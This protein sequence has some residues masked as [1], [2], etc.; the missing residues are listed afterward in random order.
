MLSAAAGRWAAAGWRARLGAVRHWAASGIDGVYQ[1]GAGLLDPPNPAPRLHIWETLDEVALAS[2]GLEFLPR[3]LGGGS[4]LQPP[5]GSQAYH[6]CH[7][8]REAFA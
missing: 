3:E 7:S 8:L 6:K 2:K 1:P 4:L 5:N